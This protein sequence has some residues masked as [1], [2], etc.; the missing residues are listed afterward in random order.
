[1][2][3]ELNDPFRDSGEGLSD[4]FEA[5]IVAAFVDSP[6]KRSAPYD[7][8]KIESS[9]DDTTVPD[10]PETRLGRLHKVPLFTGP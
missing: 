9:R 3:F 1:M 4:A 2:F 6:S 10:A 8:L 5:A 7:R